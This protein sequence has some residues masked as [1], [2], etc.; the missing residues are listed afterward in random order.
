MSVKKVDLKKAED[1]YAKIPTVKKGQWSE[2]CDTVEK[3]K[4]AVEVTDITIG[5]MAALKRTCKARGLR[6]KSTDKGKKAIVLP[7][8]TKA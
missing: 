6:C 5:Q 3:G 1:E 4:T 8:E 7:K 2:V